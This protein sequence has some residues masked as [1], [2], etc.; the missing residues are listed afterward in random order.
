MIFT[1]NKSIAEILETLGA[2]KNIFLLACNGC[3]EVCE[4]GGES[5]L[6]GMKAELEKA[7]KNVTG[8][9]LVDF[10]CNKVLVATRLAREMDKLKQ[11][12]SMLV[13]TCGVGV[14]AVSRIVDIVVHPAANTVSLGGLQGLWP[15]D[16][17]CQACGDCALDYTGGICPV[18]SCAKELLN[19][20]CGGAEDGKC[21]VDP[22][23]DCGW[24]K[25]YERLEKIGRLENLKKV[26]KPRDHSKMLPSQDL[27]KT[28]FYDLEQ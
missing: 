9:A 1:E 4:T 28:S 14:Q 13:M 17:R 22:E 6:L 5:A 23:R 20:P 26:Y 11:A 18:T 2:E 7:G 16:E 24:L 21:E 3:A 25:I 27:R 15:S 19:G 12:D 8:T 10:L